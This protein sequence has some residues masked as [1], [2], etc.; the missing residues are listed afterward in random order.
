MLRCSPENE[1]L[2]TF[3]DGD[4]DDF[5]GGNSDGVNDANGDDDY[6]GIGDGDGDDGGDVCV[7][8][9]VVDGD[10]VVVVGGELLE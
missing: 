10:D 4:D 5:G 1:D 9:V 7:G 3:D 6:Y 8:I 2:A